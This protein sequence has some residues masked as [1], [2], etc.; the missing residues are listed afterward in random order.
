MHF[1]IQEKEEHL[2]SLVR[3]HVVCVSCS[4]LFRKK[5]GVANIG[6]TFQ[7]TNKRNLR[8]HWAAV[9]LQNVGLAVPLLVLHSEG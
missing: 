4:M 6:P 2:C 5:L 8:L 1:L 7:E 3:G 9:S